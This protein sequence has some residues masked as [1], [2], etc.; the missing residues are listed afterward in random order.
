MHGV[1]VFCFPRDRSCVEKTATMDRY[2]IWIATGRSWFLYLIGI[3]KFLVQ[4]IY[5]HV[6]LM[7]VRK[8]ESWEDP[9]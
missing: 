1:K 2:L 6:D 7:T 9:S 3:V 8:Y 4:K 5:Q